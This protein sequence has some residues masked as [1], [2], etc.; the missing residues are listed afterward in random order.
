MWK[1]KHVLL[2]ISGGIAA[3][4]VPELIR[5]FIK[6]GAEVKVVAT[7]NALKFVTQLTLETLSKNK[8][9][10]ETFC[11]DNS[12]S[13]EHISHADWADLLVVA[14]AT[15]NILGKFATGI[16]DDALSTTYLAF[17][18]PVFIAPAMNCH[19]YGH[20]A[21]QENINKLRSAGVNFIEPAV[22][23]LA[24]GDYGMGRMEESIY[25]FEYITAFFEKQSS[26]SGRKIL[27]TAG[28]TYERIDPV[29]FIGNFSSG[30]MGFAL[31]EACAGRGAEVFLVAGPVSL[32]TFHP[33]IKRIDVESA[34]QMYE[35]SVRYFPEMDAA[36]LCAAVA[37]FTP[38]TTFETK[39]K[40]GEGDLLVRLKPTKDIAASLGSTKKDN[41][42]LVG[43]ALET[44]NEEENA[45]SKL[46]RKNLDFIVLNSMNDE[47]AGFSHDTNKIC[48]INHDGYRFEYP[49]KTKKE[50]AED[51][52]DSLNSYFIDKNMI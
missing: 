52:L 19:M 38:E 8:L 34:A 36:I 39:T 21:V 13:T 22:G 35:E 50:V 10:F 16:A 45:I 51:I 44:E 33:D 42:V 15:A 28:P 31:A 11:T 37:D 47:G 3:Y 23:E 1:G 7:R 4:K 43:F 12:Y 17:D 18:K 49:L 20:P 48:I 29:R 30:K 25:I 6:A 2:G 32:K 9:Y 27:L 26:W 41:Q 5:L 14:P 24:C 46:D 40:R